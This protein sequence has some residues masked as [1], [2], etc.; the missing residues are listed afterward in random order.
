MTNKRKL[1]IKD[2]NYNIKWCC[3]F[4][5]FFKWARNEWPCCLISLSR[6][7]LLLYYKSRMRYRIFIADA[8]SGC[9]SRQRIGGVETE[10]FIAQQV[11]RNLSYFRRYRQIQFINSTSINLGFLQSSCTIL[12]ARLQCIAQLWHNIMTRCK[13]K[14]CYGTIIWCCKQNTIVKGVWKI[15]LG[16][17]SL[18]VQLIQVSLQICGK[19]HTTRH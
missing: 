6:E 1:I 4:L 10:R 8:K 15:D 7:S 3:Y 12:F 14:F 19:A 18:I 9:L 17:F 16:I 11:Y 5:S 2:A 13:N